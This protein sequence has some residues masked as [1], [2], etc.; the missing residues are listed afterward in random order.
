VVLLDSRAALK[1]ARICGLNDHARV[2]S[3]SPALSSEPSV[4]PLDNM[5]DAELIRLLFAAFCTAGQR[6]YEVISGDARWADRALTITRLVPSSELLAYKAALL[7]RAMGDSREVIAIEPPL[8]KEHSFISLWDELL[9]GF[10]AYRGVLPI[11]RECFYH[12]GV[13]NAL[14][15]DLITRFRFETPESIAYRGVTMFSKFLKPCLR[16]GDIL[17]PSENSLIKEACWCLARMGYRPVTVPEPRLAS[18]RLPVEEEF[19]LEKLINPVFREALVPEMGEASTEWFLKA[20]VGRVSRALDQHRR[21]TSYWRR[22]LEGLDA[23]Y[24]RAVVTNYNAKPAGEALYD[25]CSQLNI[26]HVAAE[27]GTGIGFSPIFEK[28][29]YAHEIATCDLYLVYNKKEESLLQ[30]NRFRRG[31]PMSVGLPRDFAFVGRRNSGVN[32]TAP[33]CYVSCQAL[34]GNVMRPIAGGV[35]EQESVAWEIGIVTEVLS[36][37]PHK[38]LFKPYR[39]VRYVDGNPIHD[40]ARD[41][42]NIEVFEERIDLRYLLGSTRL[43]IFTHAASTLSWCLLSRRPVVFLDSEKQSPLYP[44]VR[45]ALRQGTFWFDADVPRFTERLREFLSRP[46]EVIEHEWEERIPARDLFI[47]RFLG[48]PDGQAG[49]RAADA[50]AA[51]IESREC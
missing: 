3:F 7:A 47:E 5:V 31:V 32:V 20:F 37:L 9:D 23:K 22:Y 19:S 30:K 45:E 25:V 26:P 4:I 8:P 13:T 16:R 24:L 51:L 40:A 14:N 36:R 15:A 12:D 11:P 39:A 29:P 21:A 17:I 35:T 27:H 38:V 6:L 49:R 43:L 41:C 10:P 1:Y 48:N 44:E 28:T 46:F 42:D 2:Y 50:I 33:I 34:M 18:S